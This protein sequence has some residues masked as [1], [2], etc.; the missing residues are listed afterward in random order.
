M[1]AIEFE[2]IIHDGVVEIPPELQAQANN[3]TAKVI[4]LFEQQPPKNN[5]DLFTSLS[6]AG[7]VLP[8]D[9]KFNRDEANAR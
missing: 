7:G 5:K 6:S 3:K 2:A 4:V 9:Y 1:Q 8:A